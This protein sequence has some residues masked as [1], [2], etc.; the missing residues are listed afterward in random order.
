MTMAIRRS[1]IYYLAALLGEI[2]LNIPDGLLLS[3]SQ[4]IH[5][6]LF[7]I[8]SRPTQ[9]GSLHQGMASNRHRLAKQKQLSQLLLESRNL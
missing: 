2:A 5:P 1:V 9:D 4:P 3:Y 6:H 7:F 8:H